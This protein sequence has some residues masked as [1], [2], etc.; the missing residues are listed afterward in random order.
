MIIYLKWHKIKMM[1]NGGVLSRTSFSLDKK[2][3]NESF[4]DL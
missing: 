1:S 4:I 3:D 2:I